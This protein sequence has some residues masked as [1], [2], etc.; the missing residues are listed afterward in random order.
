MA[1]LVL[2][3]AG[4]ISLDLMTVPLDYAARSGSPRRHFEETLLLETAHNLLLLLAT[5]LKQKTA[6]LSRVVAALSL[7]AVQKFLDCGVKPQH[8][9]VE[10]DTVED[11]AEVL[12]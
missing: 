4:D 8:I 1:N 11:V 12:Q 9:F 3:E 10:D 6:T 5:L 7:T 2:T